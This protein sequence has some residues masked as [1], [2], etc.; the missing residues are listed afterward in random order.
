MTK[1]LLTQMGPVVYRELVSGWQNGSLLEK[2]EL[3]KNRP[4]LTK[5]QQV[6]DRRIRAIAMLAKGANEETIA[7]I[8]RM[9]WKELKFYVDGDVIF[10]E[11]IGK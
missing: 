6:E 9:K 2:W 8:N 1:K 3:L 4:V 5:S 7:F 11:V 10:V